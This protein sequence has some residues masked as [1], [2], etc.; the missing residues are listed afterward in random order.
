MN[1]GELATKAA[2][3]RHGLHILNG[4][5]GSLSPKQMLEV[6]RFVSGGRNAPRAWRNMCLTPEITGAL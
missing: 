5:N 2:S 3:R 1:H 4:K 6:G